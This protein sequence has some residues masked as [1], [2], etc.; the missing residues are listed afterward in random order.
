MPRVAAEEQQYQVT[1]ALDGRRGPG[2]PGR[3]RRRADDVFAGGGRRGRCALQ[4]RVPRSTCL[5]RLQLLALDDAGKPIAAAQ[6]VDLGEG[7]AA[8]W[9]RRSIRPFWN[10]RCSPAECRCGS[11]RMP[12][13]R[14]RQ[15]GRGGTAGGDLGKRPPADGGDRGG[16]VR[17]GGSGY[18]GTD[19]RD[20]LAALS[21]A[22]RRPASDL[23]AGRRPVRSNSPTCPPPVGAGRPS[24]PQRAQA[25]WRGSRTGPRGGSGPQSCSPERTS[26]RWHKRSGPL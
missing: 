22:V 20:L 18:P 23:P 3:I 24:R 6:P 13:Y 15:S 4:F 11:G 16:N 10:M 1:A 21:A 2:L 17:A 8:R 12:V 9:R 25:S 26:R 7:A 5:E 14:L 19:G